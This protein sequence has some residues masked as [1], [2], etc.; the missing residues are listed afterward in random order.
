MYVLA[1]IPIYGDRGRGFCYDPAGSQE[2]AL[3]LG[4]G[5]ELAIKD[6]AVVINIPYLADE[7]PYGKLDVSV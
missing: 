4:L 2:G 7:T 1:C 3:E 6:A 5:C